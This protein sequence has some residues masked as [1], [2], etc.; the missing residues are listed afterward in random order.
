MKK[1]KLLALLISALVLVTMSFASTGTAFAD[2]SS[3][4]VGANGGPSIK[5]LTNGTQWVTL[6]RAATLYL[7]GE[8][9]SS[10]KVTS[11]SGNTSYIYLGSDGYGGKYFNVA[12]TY[13]LDGSIDTSRSA[14]AYAPTNGQTLKAGTNYLFGNSGSAA[15]T[16]TFKATQTGYLK[17]MKDKGLSAKVSLWKGSKLVANSDS[18]YSSTGALYYGVTKGKTYKIRIAPNYMDDYCYALKLVNTKVKETSGAKKSKAKKMKKKKVYKG[19]IQAGSAKADWYKIKPKKK[20]SKLYVKAYAGSSIKLEYFC[21][22][23][24]K[25]YKYHRTLYGPATKGSISFYNSKKSATW[26]VKVYRT[27]KYSSGYYTLKW[28]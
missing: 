23:S 12:G 24:G 7:Y 14:V 9:S 17:V 26:Y 3:M 4:K 5:A 20:N 16:F 25:T 8:S 19:T 10:V 15:N 27:N 18:F 28:K 1:K 22:G 13:R 11:P 6:S 2:S 21:K